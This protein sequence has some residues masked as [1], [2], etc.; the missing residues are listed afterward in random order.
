MRSFRNFTIILFITC[1][2]AN[3]I[4]Q[5]P[6]VAQTTRYGQNARLSIALPVA[7]VS[8]SYILEKPGQVS[9]AIYNE[10]G[11]QLRTL[12]TGEKQSAGRY[13]I[14]WDGLDRYG[15]PAVPGNYQWRLL[16]TDGFQAEFLAVIGTN[17]PVEPWTEWAGNHSPITAALSDGKVLYL[18]TLGENTPCHI[19]VP[20]DGGRIL[21]RGGERLIHG[22]SRGMD[23]MDGFI[24]D[25]RTS[26]R[27]LCS[28]FAVEPGTGKRLYEFDVKW[29]KETHITSEVRMSA[30]NGLVVVVYP[31]HHE[32]AW[33]KPAEHVS[34]DRVIARVTIKNPVDV[35]MDKA[36]TVYAISEGRIVD[37]KPGGAIRTIIPAENLSSPYRLAWVAARNELLVAERGESHLVKRFSLP[38]GKLLKTYG[39][40]GGRPYG[41]YDPNAFLNLGDVADDTKGGIFIAEGGD[42]AMH[43]TAWF[44]ADGKLKQQWFGPQ[45]FFN[46]AVAD[47]ADSSLVWI[48]GDDMAKTLCRVDYTTGNWELIAH[49]FHPTFND[50]LPKASGPH[51]QWQFRSYNGQTY[52]WCDNGGAFGGKF[53]IVRL[54][55]QKH[56]LLP[57]AAGGSVA[58]TNIPPPLLDALKTANLDPGD[59][60][61][62][63]YLW[64]DLN[65]DGEFQA[66]EFTVGH[67]LP[68]PI[69]G[70]RLFMDDDW[71]VYFHSLP[72]DGNTSALMLPN[73]ATS[74]AI[75]PLWEISGLS[76]VPAQMPEEFFTSGTIGMRGGIWVTPEGNIYRQIG[77]NEHPGDDNPSPEWP[78]LTR[79]GSRLVKWMPDGSIEWSVGRQSH[80]SNYNISVGEWRYDLITN[81]WL[82][83]ITPGNKN[84]PLPAG[85]MHEPCAI[86]GTFNNC[87]IVAD[88]VRHPATA[89][90]SD[91]LYAGDFFD[92]R[93]NDGLPNRVYS[94]WR[95]P[96][97]SDIGLVP[98][99]CLTGGSF[100]PMGNDAVLWLPMG[101]QNTPAYRVTGW[102]GWDRMDG[103]VSITKKPVSAAATGTGLKAEYFR[104]TDL[105]GKP[106]TVQ[107]DGRLWFS[108]LTWNNIYRSWAKQVIPNILPGDAFSVRWNGQIESPLSEPFSFMVLNRHSPINTVSE[109]WHAEDGGVRVWLDDELILEKWDP[110]ADAKDIS[111]PMSKPVQLEAGKKYQLRI[112]YVNWGKNPA[113]FSL[114][115]MSTTMELQRIPTRYLYPAME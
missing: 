30:G 9:L 77:L 114:I 64:S 106:A 59:V 95:D 5:P 86:L 90:T 113:Q 1:F 20:L 57:V 54:D 25:M 48:T 65:G 28:V 6:F 2:F 41:P 17:T 23:F 24:F 37:V 67:E 104:N 44:D 68:V 110:M 81:E 51:H 85:M 35:A 73:V 94:W 8:I 18:G 10:R 66:E 112:E 61:N 98:H 84:I 55:V 39:K 96:H 53:G 76:N 26:H 115:W 87:V 111:R 92:R 52:F 45:Q 58:K 47:P 29:P 21:W 69:R 108:Q 38:N 50:L 31:E 89:W 12:L 3:G 80:I 43:R 33:F 71:N 34:G 97:S 63:N 40:E 15:N 75:A 91:G 70:R 107:V 102:T 109:K 7:S 93:A 19:A 72:E 82:Q 27:G 36:G 78:T 14:N 22:T 79:G 83:T 88:R 49:Y 62:L 42:G 16:R 60:K 46:F 32:V 99:D 13:T 74:G 11:Q 101:Q 100:R 105:T 56:V 103:I 4:A